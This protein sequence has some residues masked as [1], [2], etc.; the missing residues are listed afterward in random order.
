MR[1]RIEG[2]E[3]GERREV[4]EWLATVLT[5]QCI[6]AEATLGGIDFSRRQSERVRIRVRNGGE[7]LLK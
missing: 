6:S 2:I 7:G 3:G 4:S 5:R 1:E